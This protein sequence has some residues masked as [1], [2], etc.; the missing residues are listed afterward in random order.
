MFRSRKN[1]NL[2]VFLSL[3]MPLYILNLEFKSK[4]EL[5]LMPQTQEEFLENEGCDSND[6]SDDNSSH[7]DEVNTIFN[8]Y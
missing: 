1:T 2:K 5:Q 4:E 6:S 8:F 7:D 3:I